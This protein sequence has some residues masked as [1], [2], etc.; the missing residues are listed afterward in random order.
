[1]STKILLVEDESEQR[2]LI[3][4]ILSAQGYDIK[5]VSNAERALE[6]IREE[7]FDL[8]ISDWQLPGLSGEELLEKLIAIDSECAFILIT[9]HSEASHAIKL[10]RAGA[11][12][13]LSKPFDK[14]TLLFT[15][16]KTLYTKS[17][18]KENSNLREHS[19]HRSKLVEMIGQSSVMNRL[20]SRIE[21]TAPTN[22]TVLING[23]SGTGKELAAR[24]LH[25][26]SNRSSSI[27]LPVNCAAIPESIAE[28]ELF[29]AEKGS[30]T[31]AN[32][33]RLGKIEAADSGTIFLDE[34]GELPL[35][36][37]SKLLR[38][39][40]EGTITRVGSNKEIS[41]D[42]RVVAATNRNLLDE[43]ESGNFREDLYY[44]LNVIPVTIPPLRQRH[45]DIPLL[46][47]HFLDHFFSK[48]NIDVKPLSS[49][50][51]KRLL[52][53][54]WPGNVRQLRNCLER[55]VL[56]SL[57]DQ[58]TSD[59]VAELELNQSSKQ[60]KF[61]LPDTGFNWE[62]HE[63][64]CLLQALSHSNNNRSQASKLLGLSYK[65]F[66]Y[67]LEKYKIQ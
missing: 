24:A 41:L 63:K 31:G 14:Q 43:I 50:A 56:L 51:L 37:Q 46:I 58:I 12:D 40:Q 54:S 47:H 1:M 48:H 65:A 60:G 4:S 59:D 32:K 39:L 19:K 18:E 52:A 25:K 2:K 3:S 28:A 17:L 61:M 64:E 22:A 5:D 23:E 27:F 66:L 36:L 44:R 20:F 13:Y 67:R 30:Y 11:D 53:Y 42:V 8:L 62:S 26:L 34:I 10:I 38:F 49:A 29:G 45:E 16:K 9:A 7:K 57:D 35:L 33:T 15:V 21:K 6:I 55:L